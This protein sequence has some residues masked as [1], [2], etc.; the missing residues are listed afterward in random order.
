[1]WPP[2]HRAAAEAAISLNAK[3]HFLVQVTTPEAEAGPQQA[4]MPEAVADPQQVAMPEAVAGPQQVAMPDKEGGSQA[5]AATPKKP[6]GRPPG[7]K[8][9]PRSSLE[10]A[11]DKMVNSICVFVIG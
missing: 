10:Q 6:R 3:H 11:D 7:T 4:A 5:A 1:M 8:N 9:K 2:S